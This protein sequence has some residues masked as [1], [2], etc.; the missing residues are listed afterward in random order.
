M[1][2]FAFAAAC[3]SDQ[4]E[5]C[6]RGL[7]ITRW[8][9]GKEPHLLGEAS[10]HGCQLMRLHG[11]HGCGRRPYLHEAVGIVLTPTPMVALG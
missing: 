1:D 10:G 7:I 5:R 9:E 11:K 8:H 3:A 6:P 2:A 4:I